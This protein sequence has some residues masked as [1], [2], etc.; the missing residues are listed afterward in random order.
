MTVLDEAGTRVARVVAD[1]N[2]TAT[3]HL[4]EY[5]AR[6]SGREVVN[7][8][9]RVR[10]ETVDVSTYTVVANEQTTTVVMDRD[11]EL[12]PPEQR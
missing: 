3:V 11:H 2:S 5:R 6:G 9:R 8:E 7:G 10:I 1:V 4:A 12:P